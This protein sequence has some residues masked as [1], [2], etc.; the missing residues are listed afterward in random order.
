MYAELLPVAKS[1][2]DLR[3]LLGR[4]IVAAR[5]YVH[6]LVE[7]EWSADE[8]SFSNDELSAIS[9]ERAEK[10]EQF[11]RAIHELSRQWKDR[12]G[13]GFPPFEKYDSMNRSSLADLAV[14]L[15]RDVAQLA[16]DNAREPGKTVKL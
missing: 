4:A 9:Q 5:Q 10:H 7:F 8:G 16:V 1:D 11:I 2:T 3:R 13:G 14:A 12:T 15:V 6:M